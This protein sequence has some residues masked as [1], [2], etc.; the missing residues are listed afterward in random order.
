MERIPEPEL[1][2]DLTQAAAYADAD[3]AEGDTAFVATILAYLGAYSPRRVVDLGC[4][5]G[6]ICLRLAERLS[7]SR[8]LGVDGSAAMLGHA[9]RRARQAGWSSERMG[10]QEAFLPSEAL[11]RAAF[12]L[13]V[14]NSVLH[15]IHRPEGFWEAVKWVAAPGAR[16]VIGDLRRPEG[17]EAARAL[18]EQ[19]SEGAPEVLREDFYNSLVAAFTVEEVRMQLQQAGLVGLEVNSVGDRYLRLAGVLP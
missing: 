14:S 5:P 17:P 6:N 13:V 15:H 18:V 1:M 9:M 16:V 2:E 4:G 19:Y 3:F 7:K 11:P 12:D 8:L 10:F